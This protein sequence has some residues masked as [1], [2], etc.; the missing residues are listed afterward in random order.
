MDN[1]YAQCYRRKV[2]RLLPCAKRQKR[3]IISG[4]D[5]ALND[6]IGAHPNAD[7]AEMEAHF[8]SPETVAASYVESAGT[9]E[10]LRSLNTRRKLTALIVAVLMLILVFWAG[11][12]TRA[13][14]KELDN[15]PKPGEVVELPEGAVPYGGS[16]FTG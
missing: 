12:I 16:V 2:L 11:F 13:A 14:I 5:A 7:L 3:E 15:Y 1:K 9:A 10:L 6:Y 8:G 4:F